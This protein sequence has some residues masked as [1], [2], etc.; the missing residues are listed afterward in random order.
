[1]KTPSW[2]VP[3]HDA[4]GRS[5]A[6]SGVMGAGGVGE[7]SLSMVNLLWFDN[8]LVI[9][10]PVVGKKLIAVLEVAMDVLVDVVAALGYCRLDS[11]ECCL[12]MMVFMRLRFR[13]DSIL[14]F[15]GVSWLGSVTARSLSAGGWQGTERSLW[16]QRI[17]M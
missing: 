15:L 13:F 8:L 10:N 17:Y 14:R 16:Q 2:E 7:V 12:D 5:G 6:P 3:T 1:M 4:G 11:P 9:E